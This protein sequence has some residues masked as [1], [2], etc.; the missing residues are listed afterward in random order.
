MKR[1]D[2]VQVRLFQ[3]NVREE[4]ASAVAEVLRSGW[5]GMGP[6]VSE[7]ERAFAAYVGADHCVAVNS[8]TAALH[9]AVKI[10]DLPP[11]SE[12]ITTP[13]TFISTNHVLLYE[14]LRPVFGDIEPDTGNLDAGSVR[15]RVTEKT[16]ALMMTHYGGYPCELDAFYAL[17]REL[18]IPS[19]ED[20]AHACGSSYLGRRIGSHECL[21]AFSFDPT[22]NLTTGSGGALT[23]ANPEY[24]D[25]LR[26]LRYMGV[27]RDSFRRFGADGRD[28]TWGYEVAEIGYR[29][30]MNDIAAAIGLA[31]LEYLDEDNRRRAEIADLYSSELARVPGVKLLRREDGR[32]SAGFLYAI[33]VER[34]DDL[35]R[36]LSEAGVGAAVHFKRCDSYPMYE[37]QELPNTEYFCSHALSLPMH[38]ALTDD[39]VSHV[40]KLIAGGW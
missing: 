6:K 26:R 27:D 40:T 3:P 31:Q 36:K 14:G 7:F 1:E 10:L 29:Y 39:E 34:R 23:F 13:V 15:S 4:A 22:K 30:H 33:L 11:G 2:S 35:I 16:S 8:G 17:G 32:I 37:L 24:E 21:Q 18:G 20:C 9:L 19:I 38:P 12:V 5:L 28:Y 25:K